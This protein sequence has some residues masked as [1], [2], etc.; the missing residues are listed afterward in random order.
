VLSVIKRTLRIQQIKA[1]H[2]ACVKA[3]A[4]VKRSSVTGRQLFANAAIAA[5]RVSVII[6]ETASGWSWCYRLFHIHSPAVGRRDRRDRE[7][8]IG[9]PCVV[10]RRSVVFVG[11]RDFRAPGA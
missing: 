11:Q 4:I 7:T 3:T 1:T 10:A 9:Y 8:D 6:S 2:E 5:S